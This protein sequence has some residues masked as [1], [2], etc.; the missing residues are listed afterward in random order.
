[1]EAKN[2]SGKP[3][4]WNVLIHPQLA[5]KSM[6]MVEMEN[7]L[8]FIVRRNATKAQIKREF[9]ETFNVKVN[10]VNVEITPKGQ[11]KAYIKLSPEHSAEDIASRLG[12]L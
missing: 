3:K 5:E 9:E 2:I 7:K 8:V 4:T 1:M 11:K 6:N 10:K 12:M